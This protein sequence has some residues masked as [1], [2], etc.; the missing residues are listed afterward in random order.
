[1]R[2]NKAGMLIIRRI[3]M[4]TITINRL[5]VSSVAKVVGFYQAVI[6]FVVGLVVTIGSAA[7]IFSESSGF[8]QAFGISAAVAG[9]AVLLFPLV[10]FVIGWVQ[11]VVLAFI[12]NVV[13]KE[14]KGLEIEVEEAPLKKS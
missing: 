14:S 1:M 13:F 10:A 4:K 12:L 2:S 11:G 9:F 8:L 5:N 6:G 7:R 3:I